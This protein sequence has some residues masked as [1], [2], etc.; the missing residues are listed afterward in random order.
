V[1]AEQSTRLGQWMDWDNSYFTYSDDNIEAIW[2]F[3]QKCFERRYLYEGH[4][5]LPWCTRC[6][7]S[8]SQHEMLGSY[9]E[10]EDLSLY[11]SANLLD[12]SGRALVLWTTTPWTLP[13]NVAA[14][15]HPT[16]RYE[17]V[18]WEGRVLVLSAASRKRLG[19]P[20]DVVQRELSGSELL[21]LE[22][23]TF[24]PDLP[25]QVPVR[26]VV[27]PWEEIDPEEGSGIVHIAPGCG[28]EDYELSKEL[29]LDVITPLDAQGD[30][31]D[32]F[33]WLEGR[34]A[35]V[36]ADD[37][38]ARL[39]AA[40]R[41]VQDELYAHSVPVCWRCKSHVLFRLVYEWFISVDDVREPMLAAAQTVEWEPPH[42]GSRMDDWL[43]N[44]GD[45]C[46]SRKRYWGL[47][48]PF[49]RCDDCQELTV[50][51]SRAELRE[52]ALDPQMVDDLPELHRPW[53]DEIKITCASCG[54]PATRVPEVGD[55]WLD[56]GITPFSTLGYFDDPDGWKQRFP[57]E[58]I[59]EM[60]EQVR[61]WYYSMLFMSVVLEGR[62]PY[63]RA[64]S[65]ER[66]ISETGEKFSK[67]GH[68]IR[69]DDAVQEIGADPIRYLFC[70]QPPATECRFGFEAGAQSQRRIAGLW[71]IASFFLT[72]AGIDRVE[73]CEPSTLGDALHV[74]DRWLLARSA[75]L[76]DVA[77]AAMSR[78]DTSTT[79]REAEQFHRRG[80]ELVRA[81][82]PAP[83]LAHG[84][85]DASGAGRTRRRQARLPLVAV[86]GVARRHAR[87]CADR[88]VRHRGT[89]AAS[90]P[91]LRR[92]C[93]RVGAPRALA[94]RAGRLARR[95]PARRD[96]HGP[97]RHQQFAAPTRRS[98][99][100]CAS[101]ASGTHDRGQMPRRAR[102]CC[103]SRRRSSPS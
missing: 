58:W 35:A 3:L 24:F 7:T 17:E 43:H 73:M 12:G 57:A 2:Y 87:A 61:L 22:F 55:C 97:H 78:E 20:D 88:P 90:D 103:N 36:V 31:V 79:V 16:L 81:R 64:L 4:V 14:A 71:N 45:W 89:V 59:S 8:L 49:Y 94:G 91:A 72:Y 75:Q 100:S 41:V 47:P 25:V 10:T 18:A 69:F 44:M 68:M 29:G 54:A 21:G 102:P 52:R 101:A 74:T 32:G 37:V 86:R 1:I 11:V 19:M 77:T 34:N 51:G 26:H 95:R 70:R 48:L 6:G 66:V 30:Y 42:I 38:T 85:G 27:I 83:L 28:P 53:I 99:A 62:A 65:Y 82:E 80:F 50:V 67:T 98:E 23:E 96:P 92:R 9:V 5:P 84:K 15:V 93:R 39:R 13:A 60:R 76:V 63:E 56:A 46:I 40:G 33:A